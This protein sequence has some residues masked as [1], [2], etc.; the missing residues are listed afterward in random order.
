MGLRL[1]E[2]VRIGDTYTTKDSRNIMKI[3]IIGAGAVGSVIGGR[4]AQ[5]NNQV[6]LYDIRQDHVDSVNAD[7]L[8]IESPDGN[9]ERVTIAATSDADLLPL[10]DIM[11]FLCKG[12]ATA[13]AA[14]AVRGRLSPDGIAMS[15]Q[16]GLGNE[17]V[18]S[19]AFGAPR[20]AAGSTTIG[21]IS[22]RPGQTYMT[23]ATA[24]GETETHL[25]CPRGT[26]EIPEVMFQLAD[27]LS[28]V[29]LPASV[30]LSVDSIIW[31]KLA[32]AAAMGT[33]TAVLKRSMAD[34]IQDAG[35]YEIVRLIVAETV[36]C[37]QA[38]GVP[39]QLEEVW[40]LAEQ[41]YAMAG[42]HVSSM[43]ADVV[44]RRKTEIDTIGYEVVRISRSH[45]L[46]APTLETAVRLVMAIERTYGSEL[47]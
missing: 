18:L 6:M 41:T 31:T 36:T 4:L 37:A 46:R 19:S 2:R 7:G 9:V 13:Q 35:T 42:P 38:E 28:G 3:S 30:S 22:S 34:V 32:L 44:A 26:A 27:A 43:A 33:V 1:A 11:V 25:G 8:R 39:L 45:G 40:S 14:E 5:S 15:L 16:N 17:R 29:G 21:A 23:P 20:A 10:S 24:A 47:H 12:F